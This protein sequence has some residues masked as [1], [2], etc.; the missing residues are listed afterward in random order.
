ME[1]PLKFM[2]KYGSGHKDEAK[3]VTQLLIATIL[4]RF[5]IETHTDALP[6]THLLFHTSQSPNDTVLCYISIYMIYQKPVPQSGLL[7]SSTYPNQAVP[8]L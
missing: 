3:Q 5:T 6:L 2:P 4:L 7:T 1:I 8:R